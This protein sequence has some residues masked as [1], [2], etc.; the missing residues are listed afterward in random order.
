MKRKLQNHLQYSWWVYVLIAVL[1]VVFWE[2]VFDNLEKPA[3]EEKLYVSFLG[4]TFDTDGLQS[5]MEQ[6][7]A[8][9]GIKDIFVERTAV[10]DNLND[11]LYV[12]SQGEF[13]AV[14]V[15]QSLLF[16]GL[17]DTYFEPLDKD[18]MRQYFGDIT[19]YEENGQAYGILLSGE[20]FRQYYPSEESCYLFVAPVSVH[21]GSEN[22]AVNVLIQY[23]LGGDG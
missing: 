22:S 18:Q 2:F 20:A 21:F 12:R 23:L 16:D 14:I 8:S 13:D 19:F 17:G 1:L 6:V 3:P 10:Q 7:Y 11:L 9:T 4:E 15:P 5:Q